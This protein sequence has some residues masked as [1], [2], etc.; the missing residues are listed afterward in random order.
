M[1]VQLTNVGLSNCLFCCSKFGIFCFCF[2]LFFGIC[3]SFQKDVK[4]VAELDCHNPLVVAMATCHSLTII[5]GK[6]AGD[7]LDLKMF[8]ASGWVSVSVD[9]Y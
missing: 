6:I 9:I 1:R 5:E 2:C 3:C 4:S 8:E 7:P